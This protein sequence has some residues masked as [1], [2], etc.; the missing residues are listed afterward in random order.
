MAYRIGFVMEQMLGHVTH[1]QNLQA[2]V[3]EDT[4]IRACWGL[5]TWQAGGWA[6][7]LPVYRSNWTVQAGLQARR[8]VAQMARQAP[9][10]ALFFHTQVP[11]VL[12]QGWLERI[13]SLVSLDATPL[14]YDRLGQFYAHSPGPVWLERLKWRLNRD[15][16][17]KARRLV[18]WSEWAKSGLVD[19]YE[20]PEEKVTVIPPGVDTQAW[21]RPQPRSLG[22]G[23]VRIL[24]VGGDLERKGGRL[25]LEAFRRLRAGVPALPGYAG[26]AEEAV[27]LHLVSRDPLEP[28]PGVFAY[29]NLKPNSAAL[30]QL[31]HAGDIFCL[32]T[33]GDCLPMAL[34][35]AGAAGLP[36]VSTRLAA[37]PEAVRDGETGFLIEPGDVDALADRLQ[38]LVQDEDLRLGMGAA[39]AALTR[40]DFDARENGARLL[41]L[42]KDLADE[43]PA[44][45]RLL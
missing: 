23:P 16:F 13:P 26:S 30:K 10:D 6:A 9:L 15:V 4:S 5:P 40:R 42:L 22:S 11:A 39:A 35:E 43:T 17:Q 2:L 27:E 32:P 20:V 25:L 36:V 12:A 18:T 31:Y 14:Q 8:M 28:E 41:A 29:R 3:H 21:A 45:S 19:E 44:R 37:I 38:R 7:R 24:F 33:L 34:S 1:S